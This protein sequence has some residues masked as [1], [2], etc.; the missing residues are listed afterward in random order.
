MKSIY[1]TLYI[2]ENGGE[3]TAEHEPYRD[4][5]ESITFCVEVL[6]QTL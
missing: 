6:N 1:S 3:L 5:L 2:Q 4:D